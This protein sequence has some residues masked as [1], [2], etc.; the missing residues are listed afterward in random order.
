MLYEMD[1]IFESL[2]WNFKVLL[3]HVILQNDD[4]NFSVI[5]LSTFLFSVLP[6]TLAIEQQQ[7][8]SKY[9]NLVFRKYFGQ[10]DVLPVKAHSTFRF[11]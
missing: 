4:V 7:L 5:K 10:K 3:E 1:L 8:V 9:Y 2:Q 11:H 6:V